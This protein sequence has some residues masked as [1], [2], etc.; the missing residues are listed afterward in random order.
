MLHVPC[1]SG[2]VSGSLCQR[3]SSKA[4]LWRWEPDSW[5]KACEQMCHGRSNTPIGVEYRLA[6][7]CMSS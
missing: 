2:G 1:D 4:L 5:H 6:A 7:M 3:G